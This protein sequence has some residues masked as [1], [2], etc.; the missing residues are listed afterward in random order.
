MKKFSLRM[1]L[2]ALLG[3]LA[4]VVCSALL[5]TN[6]SVGTAAVAVWFTIFRA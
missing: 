6:A 3:A 2:A 5:P 4:F 1:W